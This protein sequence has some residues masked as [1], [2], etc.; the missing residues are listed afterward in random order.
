MK[1]CEIEEKNKWDNSKIY[2]NWEDW[3]KD[4][5]ELPEKI[6][7][8]RLYKGHLLDSPDNL[9]KYF[10]ESNDI[11]REIEKLEFY[12]FMCCDVDINDSDAQKYDSVI[13]NIIGEYNSKMAF[14]TPELMSK[15]IEVIEKFIKEEPK[16]KTYERVLKEPFRLKEHLLDEK[17]EAIFAEYNMAAQNYSK[18]SQFIRSKELRFDNIT[19]SDGEIVELNDSLADKYLRSEDRDVRRQTAESL[20]KAYEHNINSLATNYIG[21]VK[22]HE[23][24]AKFRGYD[25]ELDK[26]LYE[27]KI[28]RKVYNKLMESLKKYNNVYDKYIK[29]YQ[30]T[31]ELKDIHSYDLSAE[32]TK[33]SSKKYTLDD[34]K[35]ILLDTFSIY[36]E[37]YTDIL[38][39]AFNERLVDVMP[40]DEKISGWYSAY[41]PY[42]N[43][44][45][46]GN[47]YNMVIDISSLA[48][49]LGHFVNQYSAIHTQIPLEVY[50]DTSIAEVASLTNEVLF[51]N[52]LKNKEND[53][54][55]LLCVIGN[56]LKLFAGNY[57]GAGRQAIFEER[58]HD[59][60]KN[61]EPV[62]ASVLNELW[63]D[64]T[65][66]ING[67][68][69]NDYQ[70][71]FWACI[72]HYFMGGGYYV[73][74]YSIALIAACN[75]AFK[76]LR[77]E[78]GFIDKYREFLKIGSNIDPM[79]A[80]KTLGIDLE[81]DKPYEVAIS[82]F[83]ES[84]SEFYEIMNEVR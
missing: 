22:S 44:R 83:N 48:H 10:L 68:T 58:S 47:F 31:L 70:A 37:W 8:L 20:K 51:S 46:F 80:L 15:G 5:E 64:V 43:P 3:V 18:S 6:D 82:M 84:I 52:L 54:N 40:S 55:T 67:E 81:T 12:T 33:K 17:D 7:K 21:F 76:I 2:A 71:S 29:L 13:N 57:F 24:E 19:L 34:A 25:S 35:N 72:P 28:P 73:Y 79:D 45:V 16:L 4:S 49:E 53:K 27:R 14:V 59:L 56:F 41:I 9:L 61:G 32:L 38:K 78:E 42:D 77:K 63:L 36:G 11:E 26:V 60:I 62:D 23:L 65:K 69:I 74:N 66:E 39:M 1:R 50:T 75:V 30:D